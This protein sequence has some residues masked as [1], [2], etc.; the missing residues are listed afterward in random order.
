M[1][2]FHDV[3][4]AILTHHLIHSLQELIWLSITI[5]DLEAVKGGPLDFEPRN[6]AGRVTVHGICV[7]I[8]IYMYMMDGWESINGLQCSLTIPQS[9][10]CQQ[11]SQTLDQT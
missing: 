8:Y 11:I 7:H 6:I 4:V 1:S 9:K 2:Y 5:L 3:R 10:P